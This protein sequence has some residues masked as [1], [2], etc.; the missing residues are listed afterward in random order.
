MT[1]S[2]SNYFATTFC[3]NVT[4]RFWSTKYIIYGYGV[5]KYDNLNK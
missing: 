1:N 4:L 5:E 3:V 2:V